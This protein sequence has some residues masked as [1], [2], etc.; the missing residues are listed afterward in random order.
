[1]Y[2]VVADIASPSERG[3]FVGIVSFGTNTAPALG[4]VLGTLLL[5]F[6]GWT[7]IFWFLSITAGVCLV[8]S[9]FALPE[10]A[11][12]V[13]G[14][15]S[16]PASGIHRLPFITRESTTEHF[17]IV[18]RRDWRFPNPVKCLYLLH[19]KDNAILIITISIFYMT[20]TCLQASLSSLFISIY[21]FSQLQAGLI[22]LP[23]GCGCALAA[24]G[25]GKCY[26]ISA[27]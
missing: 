3:G 18:T 6:K 21:G 24:F 4:P 16:I 20:Y 9:A 25:T 22:Y 11:R 8:M 26:S 13:V 5:A 7:S 1:M 19:D 12:N 23:F 14:N 17:G 2:G 10:T 27:S 15:G